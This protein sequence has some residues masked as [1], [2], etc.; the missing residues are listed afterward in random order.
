MILKRTFD[1][2]FLNRVCNHPEVH[3]WLGKEGEIDLTASVLD[4]NNF[5]LVTDGGGFVLMCHEPGIYEGHS[6]FL[7]EGRRQTLRAMFDLLGYMFTRTDCHTILTQVPD[8]N[9]AAQA[10]ARKG[11]WREFFRREDTPRGP[12]SFMGVTIDEWAQWNGELEADGEWFHQALEAGKKAHGSNLP[13]HPHD[14][15]HER[16]VG[17]AVKMIRAGNVEKGIGFY[18][19]WANFAGYAP[20]NLLSDQPLV[21]D[22]M[23]A[24]VGLDGNDLE[25]MLCR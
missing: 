14:P 12:T 22:V 6:Q 4:I 23:D 25:V 19:R 24:V 16:A 20:I 7:P 8:N 21:I 3:P 11:P 17:A 5:A 15:A 18:N 13:E 10:L 1:P 9:P 2:T